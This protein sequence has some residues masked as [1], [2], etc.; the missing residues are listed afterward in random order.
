MSKIHFKGIYVVKYVCLIPCSV[1]RYYD[2]NPVFL[3]N[4]ILL[5][6]KHQIEFS[7][8]L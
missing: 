6:T 5:N 3:S 8:D 1:A 7:V 2:E 4:I